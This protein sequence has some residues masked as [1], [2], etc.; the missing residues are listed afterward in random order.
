MHFEQERNNRYAFSTFY[1]LYMFYMVIPHIPTI[2]KLIYPLLHERM[3]A[4]LQRAALHRVGEHLGGD[5]A[6]L[7][8][9]GNELVDNV[10]GVDCL[11]AEFV[12]VSCGKRLATGDPASK[13]NSQLIPL[14]QA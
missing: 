8:R 1:M 2:Q 11:D 13:G 14:A 3:D 10:I 7:C 9:V 4:R 12:Q 6:A 5:A